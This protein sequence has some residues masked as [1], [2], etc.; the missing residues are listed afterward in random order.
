MNENQDTNV[1]TT[2]TTIRPDVSRYQN[3]RAASGATSKICGDEVSVLLA[4]AALDEVYSFVSGVVG[5]DESDLRSKYG[6]KNPGQQRMFLG[7]LVRGGLN[8]K[9]EEKAERIRN[10][11]NQ[12]HV[13][14]RAGVDARLKEAEAQ[15]EAEAKAK[16]E[17]KE[18]AKAAK[19]AERKA[20]AEAKA[21]AKREAAEAKAAAKAAAPKPKAPAPKVAAPKAPAQPQ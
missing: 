17:A 13:S 21:A 1:E 11:I 20:K 19:E 5:I 16:A 15:K 12:L 7:N 9:N 14:F 4:G 18:A 2:G 6:D 3:V 8:G 10:N